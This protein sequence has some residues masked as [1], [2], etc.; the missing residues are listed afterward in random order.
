[1]SIPI[2]IKGFKM[3]EAVVLAIDEIISDP[4]VR[5]GR[6]VIA[7]TTLCVEDVAI[8]YLV[9][10]YTIEQLLEYYPRLTRSKIYAALAYYYAHQVEIDAQI[11]ADEKAFDDAKAKG[12]GQR[13]PPILG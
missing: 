7:G 6:P 13:Y 3:S 4:N 8:G 10:G 12:F 9:K 11:E 5:G 2:V 1:M